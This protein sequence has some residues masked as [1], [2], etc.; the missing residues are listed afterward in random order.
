MTLFRDSLG[1]THD[2]PEPLLKA[3]CP[4]PP[5]PNAGAF[6]LLVD[7]LRALRERRRRVAAKVKVEVNTRDRTA[8][9]EAERVSRADHM[10]TV[11]QRPERPA[12]PA[13]APLKKSLESLAAEAKRMTEQVQR[14]TA[15]IQRDTAIALM[16][17]LTAAARAG[18]LDPISAAKVDAL[19]HANAR[20]LGL[21]S[22]GV[23]R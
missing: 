18:K 17:D 4:A 2:V 20:A 8:E 21:E 13:P 10:P 6:R 9:R 15:E 16:A 11:R 22:T 12:K 14:R 1:F 3:F 19:R 23:R 7:E 5:D